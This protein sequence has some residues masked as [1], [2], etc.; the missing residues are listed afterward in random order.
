MYV[1]ILQ[2]CKNISGNIRYVPTW[3]TNVCVTLH[4]DDAM[5]LIQNPKYLQQNIDRLYKTSP[6]GQRI[7]LKPKSFCII[8]ENAI[9]SYT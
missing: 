3:N 4:A 5:F 2:V 9:T 7:N 1:K 6:M 8:Y